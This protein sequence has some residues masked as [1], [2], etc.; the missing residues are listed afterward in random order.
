MFSN[1]SEIM[2]SYVCFLRI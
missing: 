2:P 1:K